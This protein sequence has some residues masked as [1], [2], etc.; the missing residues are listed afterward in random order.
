MLARG[1]PPIEAS[2]GG[3]ETGTATRANRT[4]ASNPNNASETTIVLRNHQGTSFDMG[5]PSVSA[6]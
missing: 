2:A 4:A 6:S 5:D 1:G 3:F